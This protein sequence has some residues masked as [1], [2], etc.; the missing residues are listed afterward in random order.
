MPIILRSQA[1]R[2][3]CEYD[4]VMV[5]YHRLTYSE[6]AEVIALAQKR[7]EIDMTFV[8][9]ETAKRATD[10]WGEQVVDA[11]LQPIPVP[12]GFTRSSQPPLVIGEESSSGLSQ[13]EDQ[14]QQ[15]AA[16]VSYFPPNLIE[17]IGMRALED[18]PDFL[19]RAWQQQYPVSS[20]SPI[21]V[22]NTNLPVAIAEPS[23]RKID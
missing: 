10:G 17:Q 13:S 8:W 1:E 4:G 22:P 18:T 12:R 20:V 7:G 9:L 23:V 2:L 15:I 19:L 21:D 3:P 11:D 5:Y 14:R 6:R 16:I